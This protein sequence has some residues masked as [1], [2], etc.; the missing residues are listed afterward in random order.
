MIKS[1]CIRCCFILCT[2]S[3]RAFPEFIEQFGHIIRVAL[4]PFRHLEAS[5]NFGVAEEFANAF[6]N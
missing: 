3:D 6:N 1:M 5:W 4:E 2:F